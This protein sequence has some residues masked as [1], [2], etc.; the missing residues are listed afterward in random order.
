M[1]NTTHAN[2]L[3]L[4]QLISEHELTLAK[5]VAYKTAQRWSYVEGDDLAQELILW[6]FEN[7]KKVTDYRTEE[8]GE[9]KLFVAL[10]RE[11][12]KYCAKETRERTGQPFDYHAEYSI[13]QIERAMP[14]VF[15][16]MPSQA[17]QVN[18]YTGE[19]LSPIG[20]GTAQAVMADMK[21]AYTDL[22]KEVQLVLAMRFRDGLT[23]AQIGEL[24]GMSQQAAHNRVKRAVAKMR[25]ALCS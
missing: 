21:G 22:P 7:E 3:E 12:S 11:A 25:D 5:K 10:R 1:A 18:P 13:A 20:D 4:S 8:G 23:E 16:D 14:F 2:T 17:V 24:T 19:A 15:E 6:L 9:G